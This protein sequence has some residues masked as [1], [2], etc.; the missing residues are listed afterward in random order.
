MTQGSTGDPAVGLVAVSHSRALGEAAVALA[1][2]ML[3][4]PAGEA[5]RIEVAAGL[6]ATT[7]G[8]DATEVAGAITAADTGAGVVVLMDLGSAVLSAELALELLDDPTARDRVLLCPAPLVEGLVAAAVA[9]AGGADRAGVAAEAA[10]GADAKAAQLGPV[11]APEAAP[12]QPGSGEPPDAGAAQPGLGEGG[13][14]ASGTFVVTPPHGLHARPAALLVQALRGFDAR[15]ELLASRTG[16]GPVAAASLTGVA[17]LDAG[18][19]DEIEVRARGPEAR[20]AVDALLALAAEGF[21]EASATSTSATAP[22]TT[23]ASAPT[24]TSASAPTTTSA[25]APTTTS[26][27]APT[28][29][30]ATAPTTTSATTPTTTGSPT[31]PAAP[32]TAAPAPATGASVPPA[33]PAGGP[34]AGLPGVG[35]ALGQGS[36]PLPASP[37]IAIGPARLHRAVELRVPDEKADDPDVERARLDRALDE[38]R[39]TITTVR[40]ATP[41]SEGAIFDAHLT[42]LDDPALVDAAREAIASGAAAPAAWAASVVAAESTL[43]ALPNEYL[44][45]RAADVRAVGDE[46]LRALLASSSRPAPPDLPTRGTDALIPPAVLVAADLTPAEAAVLDPEAVV[47]VVLAGGSATGHA[48]ILLRARGIPAVVGAG[49]AVLDLAPDTPL[50]LDGTTG[51]LVVDPSAEVRAVFGARLAQRAEQEAT[52]RARADEPAR[53][54]DGTDVL[55]G[56]NVGADAASA[57]GTGA[58]L[59]GLVRTEFLFL[60]RA[61]P[62]GVDEQEVAYRAVAEALGGRRIVLRTLDVGGDKPLP[63]VPMPAEANPFLGVRGLRLAL[64]RPDLLADQLRAIVRTAHA[65][66][67]SVMFPMVT[68]PAELYAARAALGEAIA[69]EG[70]GRPP[71]LEIGIMVEVP[72]AALTAAAFAPAV[73]FLSIGTNDLTQYTLAAERGS[74]E[75]AT[76]AD[77]LSPAVLRLVD[78]TCR[79]AGAALVA[80]CGELAAD[81]VAAPLLVGLGV[82]EL[83]VAPPAVALVKE[84]VRGIDAGEAAALAGRALAAPDPAAVRALL[85]DRG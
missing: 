36:G 48:A 10:A 1:R 83:S 14:E 45:A 40:D 37:G 85:A 20:E 19:G 15:V 7:F 42:M 80:V 57:A 13:A 29:T 84:A 61:E 77:P 3:H 41:A 65:T 22:T 56:V 2:E 11:E 21:G 32:P 78:A 28:T 25:T 49:P 70:R 39:R 26:A 66:P 24:T 8:T 62:P 17:S 51:R 82:R 63:Y 46:V 50:A 54:R 5:V 53:T 47:G 72:A 35:G 16:R 55:V 76:L 30:S 52:A 43:A 27:T 59:A 44:R 23:S 38:A 71:G 67:V 4:G 9:A 79:G 33:S 12:A 60:D 75:V 69:A 58:D 18:A 68:V 73:D 6:D 34:A 81:P 64:R 74:A 31:A